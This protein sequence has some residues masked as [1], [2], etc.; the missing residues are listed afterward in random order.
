MSITSSQLGERLFRRVDFVIKRIEEL[1]YLLRSRI[2]FG[3]ADVI[4]GGVALRL[5]FKTRFFVFE[6]FNLRLAAF[7]F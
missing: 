1:I 7:D 5:F 4:S 3:K 6:L 2:N